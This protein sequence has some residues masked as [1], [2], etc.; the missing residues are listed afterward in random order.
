M[1]PTPKI[2]RLPLVCFNFD[3]KVLKRI[4]S[5]LLASYKNPCNILIL[6][7]VA[8]IE[9]FLPICGEI[10]FDEKIRAK[11]CSADRKPSVRACLGDTK[12][13]VL[14]KEEQLLPEQ[15]QLPLEQEQLLPE[16]EQLLP[17]QDQ[18][19]LEQEQLLPEQDRLLPK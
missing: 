13:Q 10:L 18:L 12:E 8:G 16:Q 7:P 3:F 5:S 6:R 14:P 2:G 9:F 17:E 1:G 11:K 4:Q 19:P 15:D